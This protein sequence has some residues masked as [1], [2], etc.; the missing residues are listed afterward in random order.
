MRLSVQG[1]LKEFLG[2]KKKKLLEIERS[3]ISLSV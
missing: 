3:S 1:E 2:E